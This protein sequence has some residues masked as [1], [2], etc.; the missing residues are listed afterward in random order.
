MPSPRLRTVEECYRDLQEELC[1]KHIAHQIQV[2]YDRGNPKYVVSIL[3]F[4]SLTNLS[5]AVQ[6]AGF[7]VSYSAGSGWYFSIYRRDELDD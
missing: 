1:K 2:Q 4:D 6:K 5:Q 3:N 7:L